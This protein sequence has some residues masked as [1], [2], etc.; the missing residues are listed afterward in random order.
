[1]KII[2]KSNT[3]TDEGFYAYKNNDGLATVVFLEFREDSG[4]LYSFAIGFIGG[5]LVS[6]MGGK[7]SNELEL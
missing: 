4:E 1:M 5:T 2:Y 3:P 7:W 6:K